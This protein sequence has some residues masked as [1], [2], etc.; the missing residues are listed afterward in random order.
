MAGHAKNDEHV[1][2]GGRNHGHD[3]RRVLERLGALL[4]L[5]RESVYIIILY[6]AFVGVVSLAAPLA[7][8]AF[9]GAIAFGGLQQPLIVL[10]GLVLGAL[11]LAATLQG[12]Q[13]VVAE[14]IQQRIFARTALEVAER[15][16]RLMMTPRR[17][18]PYVNRF[19]DVVTV[20]KGAASLLLDGIQ[21][22]LGALMGSI[23]LAF[24]HYTL[25]I[26]AVFL[27]LT[28]SLVIT[29]GTR[30]GGETAIDESLAKYAVVEWFEEMVRN[31][32][33]F[34]SLHGEAW[35]VEQAGALTRRY[36]E[37]RRRHFRIVIRQIVGFLAIEVV[38]LTA[39]LLVGGFLVLSGD[40]SLGQLV[41]AELIVA[42][43]TAAVSKLG[44]YLESFY[45]LVAA[46]DKVGHLLDL[47]LERAGGISMPVVPDDAVPVVRVRDGAIKGQNGYQVLEDIDL[48]VGRRDRISILGVNGAG[49]SS[50]VDALWGLQTLSAGQVEVDGLP[51]RDIDLFS[52]RE[53]VALVR[54]TELVAGTI[55]ENLLVGHPEIDAHDLRR[56]LEKVAM[57][58]VVSGLPDGLH[59][60]LDR[61]T[62]SPGQV[63]R[64]LLAR[65]IASKPRLLL[66]DGALD[67]IDGVSR[68]AIGDAI[69]DEDAPWAV[70][71]TTSHPSIARLASTQYELQEGK[72]R[73][74]A[75]E[76]W[77]GG[78]S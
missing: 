21:V 39:L 61:C 49:K 74:V 5:E 31:H 1:H 58:D 13:W 7:T 75:R 19:L 12:L 50:L 72:L 41:A 45:D 76:S 17:A 57:W 25:A 40:I 34:R 69:F 28:L 33:V 38:A 18:A 27:L 22:L 35:A 78:N 29:F 32:V 53:K 77:G 51:V 11:V 68:A 52:L 9:V 26:F 36:V 37:A 66:I 3:L 8:Q 47:P 62:F 15:L 70:V 43:V 67:G 6:S 60:H 30:R 2:H 71:L 73:W 44:K 64:L 10:S 16:P 63:R 59:T 42:S 23:V 46:V 55:L 48:E 54:G 56:A 4:R 14:R 65:A 20:Q 24:Y